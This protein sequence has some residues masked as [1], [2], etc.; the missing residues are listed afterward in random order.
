M[1]VS[2]ALVIQNLQTI[3]I[4]GL[5]VIDSWLIELEFN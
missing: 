2:I 4:S 1:N 3:K 5:I